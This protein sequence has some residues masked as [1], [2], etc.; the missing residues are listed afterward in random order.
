MAVLNNKILIVDYEV[1][2]SKLLTNRLT[3]LGYNTFSVSNG[4][5]ALLFFNSEQ[6]DLIIIDIILPKLD[7]YEVC[8]R[9]RKNSKV[10]ILIL[11]RLN[12]IKERI[13]GLESGADDYMIKPFSPL[14]LEVH[15][16]SL[17]RRS[18][19]YIQR[20]SKSKK[21]VFQIGNLIIN[22]RTHVILKNNSEVKLTN[23]EYSILE[24]LIENI[25][26]N[27]SRAVILENIWGYTPERSIDTRIVD[28][29]ISRLR[30]KIEED[31]SNP[32]LILTKRGI[33]YVFLQP[34]TIKST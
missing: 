26:K 1:E 24:L 5:D 15:I 7:G 33:G 16:R 23:I 27:L 22:T 12:T 31:P 29:N 25:G 4:K 11:T 14:E 21:K 28:V 2:I 9:I 18:G 32:D 34:S 17:L 3:I 30:S 6:F 19:K 13:R 10:P 8:R 20:L